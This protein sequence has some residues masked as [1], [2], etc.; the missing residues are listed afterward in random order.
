MKKRGKVNIDSAGGPVFLDK[1]KNQGVITGRRDI[2]HKGM[3]TQE[4]AR[5]FDNLFQAIDHH[6]ELSSEDKTDLR[7]EIEELRQEL[8]KKDKAKESFLMRKLRNIGKMAPDILDVTL[9]TI[10]NPVLGYGLIAKK[11]A[12]RAKEVGA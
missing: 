1:V 9:A 12:A 5:L 11:I 8:S 2:Y 6:S 3:D 10:I 4:A 7:E